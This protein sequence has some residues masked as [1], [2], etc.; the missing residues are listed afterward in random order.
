MQK[1]GILFCCLLL[2]AASA[3]AQKV[4]A[5]V[6]T[7][8]FSPNALERPRGQCEIFP[9]KPAKRHS[10]IRGRGDSDGAS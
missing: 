8:G 7:S 6:P 2:L 5:T 10:H 9:E 4:V 1:R 3:M